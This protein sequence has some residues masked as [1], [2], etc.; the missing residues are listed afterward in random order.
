MPARRTKRGYEMGPWSRAMKLG[1]EPGHAPAA[2]V[3]RFAMRVRY[4]K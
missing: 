1:R 2:P 4:L 3:N